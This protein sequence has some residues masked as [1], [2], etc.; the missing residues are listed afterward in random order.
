MV[1]IEMKKNYGQSSALQAGIDY[2]QGD[3]VITLDGDLQNDPTDIPMMLD[4]LQEG[5]ELFF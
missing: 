1:L 2:A 4:L 3:Y 5:L